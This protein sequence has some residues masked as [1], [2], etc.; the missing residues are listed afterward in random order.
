MSSKF[1]F[2]KSVRDN[3]PLKSVSID[4]KNLMFIFDLLTVEIIFF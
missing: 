4:G 3:F 2:S 1:T